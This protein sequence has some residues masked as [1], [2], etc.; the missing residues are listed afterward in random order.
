MTGAI[1][2]GLALGWAMLAVLS[3]RFTDQPQKWAAVPALFLGL[4]GCLLVVFGPPMREALTWVWPPAVL[5]LALWMILQARRRLRSRSGRLLLYPVIAVL[6]LASIGGGYE[7]AGEAADA[8]AHSM[9]GRLIDVGG[10]RLHLDCTGSGSPTVVL[11]PG[12]GGVSSDLERIA[13]A[14][15]LDTRVCVYD[16]AGRGWSDPANTPQDAARIATDLHTL[17][18]RGNVPGPYVL[19]GHSFGG[20]Y[21]LTFAA[22]YPEDVA[23]LALVDSTAPASDPDTEPAHGTG[24]GSGSQGTTRRVSALAAG[25]AR[26]GIGQLLGVTPTHLQ[27]T[28]D[29]YGQGGASTQQAAALDDLTDKPLVV[30]TAG[31]GSQPGWGAAQDALAALSTNSVHRVIDGATHASFITD[32]EDAAAA[33]HGILDVV[34]AVRTASLVIP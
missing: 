11:E 1:L 4:A 33:A 28:L 27:S 8:K 32:Q 12:A 31:S 5:V 20:L 2:V 30:L 22:R 9:P 17:L 23:G 6:V 7:A 21:A 26:L 14:V 34:S 16:R 24:S 18:Q 29:E 13:P 25:V 19:A 3:G 15:A 10:H